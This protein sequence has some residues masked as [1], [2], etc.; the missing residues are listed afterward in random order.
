VGIIL[1]IL[2]VKSI[3]VFIAHGAVKII[4]TAIPISFGTN[5]KVIS[6]ICVV[7]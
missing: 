1:K 6:F 4:T 3:R 7:A 5:D 2:V